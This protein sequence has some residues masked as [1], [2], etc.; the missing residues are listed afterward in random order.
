MVCLHSIRLE[1]EPNRTDKDHEAKEEQ[2]LSAPLRV[3][4]MEHE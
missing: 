3:L 4:Y 1:P 2:H